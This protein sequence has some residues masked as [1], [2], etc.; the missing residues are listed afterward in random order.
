M[1]ILFV[2]YGQ[3]SVG[4]GAIRSVSLLRALADAGNRIDV[5]AAKVDPDPHINIRILC[6]GDSKC[7]SRRGIRLAV[8][9]AMGSKTYQVVHAVDDAII[10]VARLGKLKKTKIVYEASRCFSGS[11]GEAPS[12]QW[13][14][15]PKYCQRMEKKVLR[16]SAVVFS[17]CDDLTA[18]L[19]KVS[20]D[21]HVVQIEDI[22]AHP[23]FP[24]REVDRC[25]VIAQLE[26]GA[27]FL[28]VCSVLPGNRSELRTLLLAARKVIEKV[29]RAGFFFK[30]V[31]DEEAQSMAA[32]LDI[33]KRCVFLSAEDT[34]QFLSALSIA[35]AALFVPQPGCRYLHPEILTL[36]NSPALVVAV[37]EGAYST[38]LTDRNSL[39]VD[40]TATS[41]AEGLLRVVH[42]PLLAF[43]VVSDAQQLIA[44]RYSFSS[45]KH[46][47]RMAYHDLANMH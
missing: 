22:P 19:K 31:V 15:F 5:I 37:H 3:L 16:R 34:K 46:R 9:R 45:F 41:I 12:W 23:L 10:H 43:G 7:C 47:V 17:S 20:D 27:T 13:K 2:T 4:A 21:V 42:E 25:K 36:L 28:V 44:D 26:G 24:G 35:D 33:R 6:G 30:G 29:P 38:L 18:D 11:N 32:N 14:L 1:N 8:M 40:Y 39:L